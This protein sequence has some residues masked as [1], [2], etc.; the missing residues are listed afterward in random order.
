MHNDPCLIAVVDDEE[1]VRRALGRLL[2]SVGFE[3]ETHASG[4][5]FLRT[6]ERRRPQC[7]V[8]DVRMPQLNGFD[9]QLALRRVDARIPVLFLTSDNAPESRACAFQQGANAYLLK[10]IDDAML[11]DAIQTAL[12]LGPTE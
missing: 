4:A 3:V 7:V 2:C 1:P 11:I 6:L 5:E 10:P 12:R 9:V 8:L